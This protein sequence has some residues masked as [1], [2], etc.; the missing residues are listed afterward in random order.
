MNKSLLTVETHQHKIQLLPIHY[1]KK[2]NNI[3][4]N[5]IQ[6]FSIW[7]LNHIKTIIMINNINLKNPILGLIH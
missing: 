7:I 1:N 5:I 3:T 2:K 6:A 4:K